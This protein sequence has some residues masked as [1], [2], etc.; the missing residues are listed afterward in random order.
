[1]GE[2]QDRQIG[3]GAICSGCF[4]ITG[5]VLIAAAIVELV[6]GPCANLGNVLFMVGCLR[7]VL[8][9]LRA[10][11][12]EARNAFQLGQDFAAMRQELHVVRD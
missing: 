11:S 6:P 1:M 2:W 12:D 9:V 3:Y 4:W 5:V 7:T 8:A 10:K